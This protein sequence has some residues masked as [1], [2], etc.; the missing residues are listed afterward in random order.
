MLS[1]YLKCFIR[2]I[3]EIYDVLRPII[4]TELLSEAVL[5]S[6]IPFVI[7]LVRFCILLI[8]INITNNILHSFIECK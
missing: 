5:M 8:E 3:H 7:L 2:T 6:L 4:L 1:V